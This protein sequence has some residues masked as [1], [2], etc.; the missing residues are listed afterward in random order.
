VLEFRQNDDRFLFHRTYYMI[1][2]EKGS[3]D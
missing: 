1:Y 2:V 3:Y